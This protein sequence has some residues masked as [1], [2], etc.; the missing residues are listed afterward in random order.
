MTAAVVRSGKTDQGGKG[1]LAGHEKNETSWDLQRWVA[2]FLDNFADPQVKPFCCP[3]TLRVFVKQMA[4]QQG[5][6]PIEY[7]THSLRCGAAHNAALA[8]VN[9]SAIKVMGQWESALHDLHGPD[10]VRGGC[11]ASPKGLLKIVLS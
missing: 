9:D 2:A 1:K 6:D 7:S 4:S 10:T 11:A 8:G 5:F 3:R